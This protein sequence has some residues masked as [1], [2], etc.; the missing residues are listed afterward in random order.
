MIN[1]I[2]EKIEIEKEICKSVICDICL[3]EFIN[4]ET[5]FYEIQEFTYIHKNCGYGS[6]F[7]DEDE[8]EIDICQTCLKQIL[9]E[10]IRTI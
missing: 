8:I 4:D 6:V 1:K 3:H 10:Y 7:G 5:N 9:G 2:K